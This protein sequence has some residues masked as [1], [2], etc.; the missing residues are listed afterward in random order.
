MPTC[1]VAEVPREK[2]QLCGAV[3]RSDGSCECKVAIDFDDTDIYNIN[4]FDL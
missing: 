3:F 2:C 1:A 4:P